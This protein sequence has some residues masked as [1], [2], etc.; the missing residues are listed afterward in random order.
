MLL[1]SPLSATYIIFDIDELE[2]KQKETLFNLILR[3]EPPRVF[4]ELTQVDLKEEISK[5]A[6]NVHLEWVPPTVWQLAALHAFFHDQTIHDEILDCSDPWWGALNYE[7]SLHQRL[8]SANS[9][10]EIVQCFDEQ[11]LL[12]PGIC[13]LFF[14]V[15]QATVSLFQRSGGSYQKMM[16]IAIAELPP[17][18]TWPSTS[19][20]FWQTPWLS[21]TSSAEL[22]FKALQ[23]EGLMEKL[24]HVEQTAHENGEWVL[25]RGYAGFGFPSTLHNKND[26]GHALSFGSTLL[27]GTFYSL[28][29]TAL[30]YAQTLDP[31]EHSFLALRVT[32][33]ELKGLFRVGPLHPFIQLLVDGEMFHAHNK[34][35]AS[36]ATE[37]SQKPLDGYFMHCNQH[38]ID[39]VGYVLKLNA[40]PQELETEFQKIC[41][42]SGHLFS[43]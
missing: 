1:I 17:F 20:P 21:D 3:Y 30:T 12:I 4:Y 33:L 9:M 14:H 19:F 6:P 5:I 43:K 35:A 42:R 34:I 13:E 40:T 36:Q 41:Q 23:D 26:C 31:G 11:S 38:C 25:Y 16:Q 24:L 27:G 18:E 37:Y 28:G 8:A 15:N 10:Q 39:P 29:S 22:F 7:A 2:K 32:P